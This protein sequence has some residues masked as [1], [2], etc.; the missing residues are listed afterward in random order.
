L[1]R[2]C[3]NVLLHLPTFVVYR[4]WRY[5]ARYAAFHTEHRDMPPAAFCATP[6]QHTTRVQHAHTGCPCRL[7][8]LSR[9]G[10]ATAPYL[11][12]HAV[13]RLADTIHLPP[14]TPPIPSVILCFLV[15]L[16]L[17]SPQLSHL[18]GPACPTPTGT[19][20]R[21]RLWIRSW[22]GTGNAWRTRVAQRGSAPR[23][24]VPSSPL[25][26]VCTPSST[27]TG[28]GRRGPAGLTTSP[29]VRA[30]RNTCL[31]AAVRL[32]QPALPTPL[33]CPHLSPK[34]VPIYHTEPCGPFLVF[35]PGGRH[36]TTSTCHR[37]YL[38]ILGTAI[39]GRLRGARCHLLAR[40]AVAPQ[41]ERAFDI[42]CGNIRLSSLPTHAGLITRPGPRFLPRTRPTLPTAGILPFQNS[43]LP[44][45]G[46]YHGPVVSPT[47]PDAARGIPTGHRGSAYLPAARMTRCIYTVRRGVGEHACEGRIS[48]FS[49]PR[50]SRARGRMTR[51][52]NVTRT[53]FTPWGYII[54]CNSISFA[55]VARHV[56]CGA[57][58]CPLL[59]TLSHLVRQ[60][61]CYTPWFLHF[62]M[63][64][65]ISPTGLSGGLRSFDTPLNTLLQCAGD[66]CI[67]CISRSCHFINGAAL[68]RH[69]LPSG[70]GAKFSYK[71]YTYF[72]ASARRYLLPHLL[73]NGFYFAMDGQKGITTIFSPPPPPPPP[74]PGFSPRWQWFNLLP[75]ACLSFLPS[76]VLLHLPLYLF[77]TSGI[78]R[79]SIPTCCGRGRREGGEGKERERRKRKRRERR[80]EEEAHDS[81]M[82]CAS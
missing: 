8:P 79:S 38:L 40:V 37:R 23:A 70:R 80:G 16:L 28:G 65:T 27:C 20:P 53:A 43:Y 45:A 56:A 42:R 24:A 68:P 69:L 74:P 7:L 21:H 57:A 63:P 31:R 17:H 59:P 41:A 78:W 13:I 39:A 22:G 50:I 32:H 4:G 73:L 9:E 18:P 26:G 71:P 47:L 33:L 3:D 76:Y 58:S 75:P 11:P 60:R 52:I 64:S 30:G 51:C 35:F 77:T 49:S 61:S 55:A 72:A 14:P 54:P 62:L 25:F 1:G 81:A 36:G 2:A 15:L 10:R 12:A 29:A 67:S 82:T 48:A 34:D 46:F 66:G 6:V 19:W 5:I 44:L